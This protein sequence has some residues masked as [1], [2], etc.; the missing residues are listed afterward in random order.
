MLDPSARF[1]WKYIVAS[2]EWM[3]GQLAGQRKYPLLLALWKL[4]KKLCG[5][6]REHQFVSR[7]LMHDVPGDALA[8]P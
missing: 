2:D 7:E 3:V 6:G 1:V 4:E 8:R 5:L